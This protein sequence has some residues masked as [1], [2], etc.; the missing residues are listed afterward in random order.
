MKMSLVMLLYFYPSEACSRKPLAVPESIPEAKCMKFCEAD[1][2]AQVY[3]ERVTAGHIDKHARTHG[4]REPSVSH[5]VTDTV[6]TL[7][8]DDL[9]HGIVPPPRQV[10]RRVQRCE[11]VSN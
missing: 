4:K 5:P 9:S 10:R 8:Q 2:S 3:Y 6:P 7:A 11:A 1:F